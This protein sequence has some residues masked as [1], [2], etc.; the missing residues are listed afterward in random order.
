METTTSM[1][2]TIRPML[3]EERK[4]T[5]AQSQ[6][7]R[8]QTG[9]IGHLRGYFDNDGYSFF[10]TWDE[11]SSRLKT[12]EFKTE[13]DYVVNALRFDGLF[14]SRSSLLSYCHKY[15]SSVFAGSCCE[16][17][18]FRVDTKK[19][20]YLIRCNPN[21]GEYNFY[22]FCYVREWLDN[23]VQNASRGIRFINPNYKE[24]FRISDGEKIRI[25]LSDGEKLDKVCRYIDEYHVEVGNNLYHICEFAERMQQCGNTVAPLHDSDS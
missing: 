25:T 6:Q 16:E 4:Y 10:T 12:D 2:M 15:E 23:H 18:G 22:V 9:S 8:G 14:K 24:L 19:Y 11:H 17:Y 13:L 1:T 20:T 7:I 5:Y 21:K 3:P